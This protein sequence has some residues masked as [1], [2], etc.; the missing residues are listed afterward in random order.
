MAIVIRTLR[1]I[2][3]FYLVHSFAL[4]GLFGCRDLSRG[5]HPD[6][7]ARRRAWQ[8]EVKSHFPVSEAFRLSPPQCRALDLE[9]NDVSGV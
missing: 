5:T 9:A 1:R 3:Q 4:F 2:E 6:E 8:C 7:T